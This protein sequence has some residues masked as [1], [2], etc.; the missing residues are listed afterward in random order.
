MSAK[1][2]LK[3]TRQKQAKKDMQI[4]LGLFDKI[5]DH[6]LTC[7]APYDK[8]NREHVMSWNVVVREKEEKVNLYC[9]DCWNKAT[10]LI[11]EIGKEINEKTN[12]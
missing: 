12:V 11:E 1:R 10:N 6:C 4:T 3:R 7:F 5:P 8:M 9:P 2:K